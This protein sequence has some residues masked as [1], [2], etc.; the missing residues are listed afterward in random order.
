MNQKDVPTGPY[1]KPEDSGVHLTT[2]IYLRSNLLLPP[3]YANKFEAV[4]SFRVLQLKF[5]TH[6]SF[7]PDAL[8]APP[9]LS[10]FVDHFD[11]FSSV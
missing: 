11:T 5:G 4:S 6:F 2:R 9:F 1:P 8:H 10:S 3:M 7:S